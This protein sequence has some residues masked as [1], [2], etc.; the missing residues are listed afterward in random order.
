MF[1]FPTITDQIDRLF[2]EL[3][4]RRWG[5][6]PKVSPAVWREVKDGWELEVPVPGLEAADIWVEVRGD[7]LTV[8]GRR[9]EKREQQ[10][11][12]APGRVQWSHSSRKRVFVRSFALPQ[13]VSPEAVE[14]RLEGDILRIRIRRS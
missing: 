13:R 4:H 10:R 1:W 2:E 11:L 9:Q 3:I 12:S 7:E 6:G 8:L 14:A 5:L